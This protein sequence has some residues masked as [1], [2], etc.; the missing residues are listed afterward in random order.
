MHEIQTLRLPEQ[1]RVRV[2][3]HA[4]RLADKTRANINISQAIRSLIE[5]GLR[6]SERKR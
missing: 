5:L 1:V 4:K 2:E 3:A 6:E